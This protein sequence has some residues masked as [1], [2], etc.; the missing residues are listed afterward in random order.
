MPQQSKIRTLPEDLQ[1]EILD[2]IRQ[3]VSVDDLT[4]FIRENAHDNFSISRTAVG[5]FAQK[6]R[7]VVEK[8]RAAR[9][10]A[11]TIA[12]KIGD[13]DGSTD[14]AI[15]DILGAIVM[16]MSADMIDGEIQPDTVYK[17][18]RS[19]N[20]LAR[21]RKTSIDA[22]TAAREEGAAQARE[23]IADDISKNQKS[24]GITDRTKE[25]IEKML[26]RR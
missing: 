14:Q 26:G 5:N 23:Q 1:E 17:L 4:K 22:L 2:L 24:L 13:A 20:Q 11:K 25:E 10:M 19:I 18:A 9:E 3:G 15:I 7:P 6:T 12:E 21:A 8:M 16:Q